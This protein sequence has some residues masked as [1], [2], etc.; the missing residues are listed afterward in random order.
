MKTS[1]GNTLGIG[2]LVFS[3]SLAYATDIE[4][5]AEAKQ[6]TAID[7]RLER[8][9][10]FDE[11]FDTPV[12][13]AE[14]SS[15]SGVPVSWTRAMN[16]EALRTKNTHTAQVNT[17][18][19]GKGSNAWLTLPAINQPKSGSELE[20]PTLQMSCIDNISRVEVILPNELEDGRVTISVVGSAVQHWRSDETG[21]VFSSGRGLPAIEM[22]RAMA[23]LDKLVLR[24]N[25]AE[26]DGLEFESQQLNQSLSALKQRCGW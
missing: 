21:L 14:S 26:L 8:L 16:S 1:L 24:S 13:M 19:E 6:C 7:E 12:P 15:F 5:L 22:M 11:L 2:L 18:G 3:S 20:Y 25:S 17:K 4:L 10:C 9:A 23:R